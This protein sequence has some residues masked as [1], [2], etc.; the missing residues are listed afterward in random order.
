MVLSSFKSKDEH[1]HGLKK[2]LRSPEGLHWRGPFLPT[3]KS[4]KPLWKKWHCSWALCP[5]VELAGWVAG[6]GTPGRRTSFGRGPGVGQSTQDRG[7]VADPHQV[8]LMTHPSYH[9]PCATLK[10]H[11]DHLPCL[12]VQETPG[13]VP[14]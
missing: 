3:G 12:S 11:P 4:R 2:T 9:L 13:W 1:G 5:D 10:F 14:Q 8:V 6:T 7:A